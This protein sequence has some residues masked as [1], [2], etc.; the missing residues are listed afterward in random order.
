VATLDGSTGAGAITING[1]YT[2]DLGS[3]TFV[4]GTINNDGN[5]QLNGG[6]GTNT[7]LS[8]NGNTTLNGGT[9]TMSVASGGGSTYIEQAVGGLTLTNQG[10]IQGAGIIGNG[11]LTVINAP[12]GLIDANASAETLTVN[13]GSL[14]NAGTLQAESGSTL[15][16]STGSGVVTNTGTVNVNTGGTMSL[17]SG[18]NYDQTAGDTKVN[19]SFGGSGAFVNVS[20]GNIE[21]TGT[22][23]GTVTV[24]GGTIHA[25]DSPGILTINGDYS[26]SGGTFLADLGGSTAGS[27]YSQLLVNGAASVTGGTLDVSLIGGFTPTT[28]ENFFL[29]VATGGVTDPFSSEILPFSNSDWQLSYDGIG[30]CSQDGTSG[31]GCLDL[32]YLG[33]GPPATPEPGTFLLMGTGFLALYRRLRHS[34]QLKR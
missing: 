2:G 27:G 28:D 16:L 9:V 30:T 5:I 23:N 6:G 19:G 3:E 14:T 21:G 15:S 7:Y 11:G 22:I 32:E 20:G 18:L 26:Q 12:G 4:L 29:I 34:K 10:T 17:A 31:S 8:L 1:T 33:S 24:S 25:G 13:P